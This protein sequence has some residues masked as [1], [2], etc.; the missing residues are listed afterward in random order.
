MRIII[1]LYILILFTGFGC[2][3]K[4]PEP[5][6]DYSSCTLDVSK[7]AGLGDGYLA[8]YMDGSLYTEGQA[9]SLS[10]LLA[11]QLSEVGLE[12]FSQPDINSLNGFCPERWHRE[13]SS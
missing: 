4:F 7:F 12:S 8:G 5:V 3:Y 9:A 11:K 6:Q 2:T 1:K 10:A 13:N